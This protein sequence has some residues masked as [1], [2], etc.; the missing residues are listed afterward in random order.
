MKSLKRISQSWL[1]AGLV[2]GLFS[3][4]GIFVLSELLHNTPK[5]LDFLYV[6]FWLTFMFSLPS[7]LLNWV[8]DKRGYENSQR[9]WMRSPK[10]Y[11]G[12]LGYV[13]SGATTLWVLLCLGFLLTMLVTGGLFSLGQAA[14]QT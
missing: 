4:G 11:F 3:G 13:L 7:A 10:S 5:Y 9:D 1:S 2:V 14:W 12:K 6:I 8:Y